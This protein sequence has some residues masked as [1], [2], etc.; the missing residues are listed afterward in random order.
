MYT[1]VHW[2]SIV[3]QITTEKGPHG[4]VNTLLHKLKG[5]IKHDNNAWIDEQL[6]AKL[7]GSIYR[8]PFHLLARSL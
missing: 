2:L 1:A 8:K 7:S 5:K 6:I 4:P 3:L